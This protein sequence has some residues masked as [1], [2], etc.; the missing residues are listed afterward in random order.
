MSKKLWR[1]GQRELDFI[2]E[3]IDSGLTGIM[4]QRL[5]EE[6]AEKIGV[7]YAIGVNSGTSALHCCLAAMGI[8]PSDEVIVPPLTFSSTAFS[9]LYLGAVSVFADIDPDTFNIDPNK[10]REKITTRT[11]AII[12][13][14]LYG[15]PADMDPI[16]EIAASNNLFVVEDS[17]ES[18]LGKYKGRFSGTIGDMGI[19]SFERSKHMTT[20]NGGMIITN[21]EELAERARR[22]SVLGYSTLKAGACESKPS[23]DVIQNPNFDRHLFVAP[24]YRL[25]EVCAAMA[26][27]QLEKLDEFVKMRMEISKLYNDAVR[28]CDW[29]KPQEV[30]EGFVNSYWTY[31]MKLEGEDKGISWHHFRKT[32]LEQGGDP[33]YAAW[34]L[35]YMEPALS[36]ME[37]KESNIKYEKGL[38]PIAEKIQP[39][40]IQLKTNYGDREYAK[41]QALALEKTIKNLMDLKRGERR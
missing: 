30:P 18:L 10:I 35:S 38:C 36:G 17:A 27:A 8:G 20:G 22:F 33:F 28:D 32:Y 37:F 3:A 12:P 40:L 39:K 41:R 31:A 23:K 21:N 29:L 16:M 34:K 2:K 5:E 4:N 15:L 9:A 1:V 11:K 19:F 14:A 7:K 13:V 6:F 26:L 24:N 25:P